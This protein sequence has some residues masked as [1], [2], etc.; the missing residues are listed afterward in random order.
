MVGATAKPTADGAGVAAPYRG[1]APPPAGPGLVGSFAG[2]LG[3]AGR[4][5]A[6]RR[7]A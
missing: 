2:P 1:P 5:E 4:W 3:A 7:Q 6:I